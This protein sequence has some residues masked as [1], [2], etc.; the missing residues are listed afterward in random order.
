MTS[1]TEHFDEL[2]E[3][4]PGAADAAHGNVLAA[5]SWG[6]RRAGRAKLLLLAL[7]LLYVALELGA[8]ELLIEAMVAPDFA[9]DALRGLIVR[10]GGGGTYGLTAA[11]AGYRAAIFT[12]LT[13]ALWAPTAYFVVLFAVVA[14]GAIAYLHAPRPAPFLAQLGATCG[15]FAG[16]FTRLLVLQGGLFWLLSRLAAPVPIADRGGPLPWIEVGGA[17]ITLTLV[18][19]IFDYARVRTVARDSRSMLIELARSA[20][21]FL[22]NLPRTLA[23]ELLLLLAAVAAAYLAILLDS[24]LRALVMDSTAAAVAGQALVIVLLWLRLVAWGAMLS[25]YQGI[26]LERLQRRS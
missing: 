17:V 2:L 5:F 15:L 20:A 22:R 10:A 24:G 4:Q 26:T 6:V 7:W 12:A 16:R 1:S 23:L 19:A 3:W 13:R 21:F 8:A 9:L 25:L 18:A 14:G 11:Q